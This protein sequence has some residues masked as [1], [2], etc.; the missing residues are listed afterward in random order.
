MHV[1]QTWSHHPTIS[2]DVESRPE[3]DRLHSIE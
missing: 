1:D 2:I 3:G